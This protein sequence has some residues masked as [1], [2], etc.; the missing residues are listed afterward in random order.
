MHYERTVID[1]RC[2]PIVR[3]RVFFGLSVIGRVTNR[4][5]ELFIIEIFILLFATHRL[6]AELDE[7]ENGSLAPRGNDDT[8][9]FRRSQ[10]TF[11]G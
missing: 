4:K 2:L 6:L 11:P 5:V 7:E 1:V 9:R 10:S 8:D 3:A